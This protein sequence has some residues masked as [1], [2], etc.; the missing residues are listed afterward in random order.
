MY[1]AHEEKDDVDE[2]DVP[3]KKQDFWVQSMRIFLMNVFNF[4]C[5]YI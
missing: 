5:I 3:K 1:T 4:T 2:E